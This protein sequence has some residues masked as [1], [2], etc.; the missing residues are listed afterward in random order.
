MICQM[1]HRSL[2]RSRARDH[3]RLWAARPCSTKSLLW[4]HLG[5]LTPSLYYVRALLSKLSLLI[6]QQHIQ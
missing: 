3:L 2:Y 5:S 4:Q 1:L 6:Y